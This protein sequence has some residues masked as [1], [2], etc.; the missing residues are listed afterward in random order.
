MIV[1]VAFYKGKGN[2]FDKLIRWWTKSQYSHCELVIH[3]LWY[4][5]SPR[6][7]K[8]R[9]EAINPNSS[10]WDYIDIQVSPEQTANLVAFFQSR[11]GKKYDWLGIALSQVLP[12]NIDDPKRWFCSEICTQALIEV[13][14]IVSSKPSNWYS[15]ERLYNKVSSVKQVQDALEGRR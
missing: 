15:P 8:V 6:N 14:A 10:H 4:S 2:F 1:K 7:G 3:N 11:I 12:L 9:F 5:S 13:G